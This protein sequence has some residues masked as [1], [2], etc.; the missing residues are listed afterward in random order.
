MRTS[1]QRFLMLT[2]LFA[3]L[4]GCQRSEPIEAIKKEN[5]DYIE[6][7]YRDFNETS[8]VSYSLSDLKDKAQTRFRLSKQGDEGIKI[9]GI[10]RMAC[11]PISQK[12]RDHVDAHLAV[13]EYNKG[14]LVRT[15]VASSV[16][17]YVDPGEGI[18]R[19]DPNALSEI[20]R[21]LAVAADGKRR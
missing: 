20:E 3:M 11:E 7:V 18:C 19:M 10:T 15:F 6:V 13:F 4:S 14:N 21:F 1:Y 2:I 8:L 9:M 16:A 17:F 5:L 12:S